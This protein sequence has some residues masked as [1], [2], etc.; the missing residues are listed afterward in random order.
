MSFVLGKN[1]LL[2]VQEEPE[3]DCF[4]PIR[5]RLKCN[6]GI[7]RQQ[8]ADYLLYALWDAIIDGYFLF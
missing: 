5:D 1:Y 4:E 3:R 6:R 8:Q 2:T 7:I